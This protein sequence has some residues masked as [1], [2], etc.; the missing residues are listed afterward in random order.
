M[1]VA[2]PG[3]SLIADAEPMTVICSKFFS[4][5]VTSLAKALALSDNAMAVKKI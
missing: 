4:S 5:L 2:E 3:I 1:K